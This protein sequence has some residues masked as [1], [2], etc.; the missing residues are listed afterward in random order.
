MDGSV[1]LKF[2]VRSMESATRKVLE[3]ADI[4]MDDVKYLFPHQA[5]IRII[6]GALE[7]LGAPAEKV[8]MIIHKYGNISTA[9][10]PVALDEAVNDGK[11]SKGDNLVMVGFG[12]GLTWGSILI[13]WSK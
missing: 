2:A 8:P 9:S 7:R 13:K 1:V 3:K 12:G 6:D 5:N 11:L 10:I 4:T